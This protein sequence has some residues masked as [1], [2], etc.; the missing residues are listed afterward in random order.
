MKA[1]K[2]FCN[3]CPKSALLESK[4]KFLGFR[5][6]IGAPATKNGK[7]QEFSGMGLGSGIPIPCIYIALFATA[8]H[9]AVH[10][11]ECHSISICVEC[12]IV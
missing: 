5:F 8:R 2:Y 3:W 4:R 6:V 7:G 1:K 11:L 10:I 9:T 12:L